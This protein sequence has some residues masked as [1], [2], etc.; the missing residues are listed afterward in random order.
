MSRLRKT[1]RVQ[2]NTRKAGFDLKIHCD[3]DMSPRT[4]KKVVA[5]LRRAAQ[6]IRKGWVT[7]SK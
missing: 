2:Q 1:S 4:A 7:C 5:I 3:A 6:A